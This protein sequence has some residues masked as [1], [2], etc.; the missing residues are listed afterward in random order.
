MVAVVGTAAP[1][2]LLLRLRSGRRSLLSLLRRR[3]VTTGDLRRGL[4]WQVLVREP[5]C[6]VEGV[7]EVVP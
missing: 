3:R 6:A 7:G 4:R 2:A 5:S 1:S